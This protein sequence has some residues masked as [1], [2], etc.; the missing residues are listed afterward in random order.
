MPQ[1]AP[2]P[3]MIIMMFSL[4]TLLSISSI[5]FFYVQHQ[6]MKKTLVKQNLFLIKW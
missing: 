1:M 4:F 3:W 5:I 6:Q 2:M